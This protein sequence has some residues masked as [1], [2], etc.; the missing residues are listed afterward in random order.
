MFE[1]GFGMTDFFIRICLRYI[2]VVA[3][4][5]GKANYRRDEHAVKPISAT[6]VSFAVTPKLTWQETLAVHFAC[7]RPLV[8]ATR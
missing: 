3:K 4:I 8:H 5:D 2:T 6:P 1:G 7:A